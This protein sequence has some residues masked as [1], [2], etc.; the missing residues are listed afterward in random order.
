MVTTSRP[1][2]RVTTGCTAHEVLWPVV[3]VCDLGKGHLGLHLDDVHRVWW[4][5]TDD[6]ARLA[7][8]T[9]PTAAGTGG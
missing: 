4:T 2:V 7:E 5:H 1:T 8:P 6:P 3:L 9:E